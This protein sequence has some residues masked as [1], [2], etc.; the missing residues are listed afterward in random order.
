MLDMLRQWNHSDDFLKLNDLWTSDNRNN[1][2]DAGTGSTFDDFTFLLAGRVVYDGL[3]QEAIALC[4]RTRC[5]S[6]S[7]VLRI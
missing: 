2:A 5:R 4:F 7:C 3:K 1:F 6:E